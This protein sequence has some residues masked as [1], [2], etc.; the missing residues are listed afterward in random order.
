MPNYQLDRK[1][2]RSILSILF[3]AVI[4]R[5]VYFMDFARTAVFNILPYSDSSYY[6]NWARDIAAGD[7]L[8]GSRVFMK[9]PL[10]GYFL[11]GLFRIFGSSIA[12]VYALQFMLGALTCVLVYFI[13]KIM[14]NRAVGFIAA[15]FYLSYGLF[16]YYEGTLIYTALSLFLNCLLFLYFLH[17]SRTRGRAGFFWAGIFSGLCA[18]AQANII[19]F[20]PLAALWVLRQRR[21]DFSAGL[22]AMLLF[23]AGLSAVLG[24]TACRNYIVEKDAALVTGHV[25]INFYLGNNP[26]ATGLFYNPEYIAPDQEGMSKDARII[27]ELN[28]GRRLKTS[29]V[30]NFWLSKSFA[31]I[32]SDPRAFIGLMLKKVAYLF[33]PFEANHDTEYY[34]IKDK[35]RALRLVSPDLRYILPFFIVGAFLGLKQFRKNALIY[36]ALAALSLSI[37]AFFVCTRYRIMLVPFMAVLAALAINSIWEAAVKKKYPA[38]AL[39]CVSV[40]LV[41]A[42]LSYSG[43]AYPRANN[44]VRYRGAIQM[45]SFYEVE[46]DRAAALRE[47]K[48]AALLNPGGRLLLLSLGNLYYNS[49]DYAAAEDNFRKAVR[50]FPLYA[51]AY[52]NLG[53]MYNR[54][55]R[56][57]EA[58]EALEEL[59]RLD[60]MDAA[61]HFELGRAYR[62]AGQPRQ[63]AKEFA[64]AV[65]YI[66]AGRKAEIEQ[67]RAESAGL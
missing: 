64:L 38:A 7:I 44:Y 10:Y 18:L 57:K 63:A 28:A 56:F 39:L 21:A 37:V 66:G 29:Q 15:L 33:V 6:F 22:Y 34:L 1:D 25:G 26:E 20:A 13:G 40:V 14:F 3:I 43:K 19:L 53:L 36:I 65:K 50:L 52:Y 11:A 32:K 12:V 4:I 46:N 48:Q 16:L 31:F 27:A 62:F 17:I 8:G 2:T 42:L 61:A 9:W 58:S 45:A 49:G 35:V 5:A 24:I 67:I 51:D 60:P 30:S 59:V 23:F 47:L 55:G 54:Q 41:Y